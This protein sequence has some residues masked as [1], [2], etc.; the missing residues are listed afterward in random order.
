M[1]LVIARDDYV[2]TKN[3]HNII[4]IVRVEM[5]SGRGELMDGEYMRTQREMED[6]SF[7][8]A[9]V[10]KQNLIRLLDYNITIISVHNHHDYCSRQ[11]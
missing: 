11:T 10:V 6:I 5:A 2:Y 9:R 4:I 8:C 3:P 7:Q 1:F